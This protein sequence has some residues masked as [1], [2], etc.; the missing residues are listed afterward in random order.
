MIRY[1]VEKFGEVRSQIATF[2]RMKLGGDAR[3]R[4]AEGIELPMVERSPSLF[5]AFPANRSRSRIA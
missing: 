4:R 1:T 2:G 3:C 5:P